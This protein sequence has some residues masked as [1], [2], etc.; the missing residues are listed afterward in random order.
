LVFSKRVALFWQN[1]QFNPVNWQQ[2]KLSILPKKDDLANPNKWRGI[3]LGDIAAK[4]ISSII[5][6][7]LTKYLAKFGIDKQF[8]SLF[9]KRCANGTFTLKTALQI[10]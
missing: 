3:A 4:C 5:A 10:M 9:S 1:E 8:G 6:T 7:R 2:I